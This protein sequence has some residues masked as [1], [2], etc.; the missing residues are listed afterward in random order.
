MSERIDGLRH[1]LAPAP[2]DPDEADGADPEEFEGVPDGQQDQQ[3]EPAR[4]AVVD[5]RGADRCR[6]E[7]DLRE[8]HGGD[9]PL[10]A[11]S[12]AAGIEQ[13]VGGCVA[14][15]AVASCAERD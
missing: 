14:E 3:V 7:V 13:Q 15:Y 10:Q 12:G 1:L 2:H 8:E 6:V 9:T 4:T 11:A 5:D